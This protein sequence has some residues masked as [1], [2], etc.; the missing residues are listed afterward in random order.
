MGDAWFFGLLPWSRDTGGSEG[1]SWILSAGLA[2]AFSCGG[3]ETLLGRAGE[4]T[5]V[6]QPGC[7]RICA[8]FLQNEKSLSIS[9]IS[10]L[11]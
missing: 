9:R 3:V 4:T 10:Y 5:D 6:C 2:L 8:G 11:I 1:W 7:G